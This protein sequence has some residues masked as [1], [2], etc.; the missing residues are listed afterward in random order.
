MRKC[1]KKVIREMKREKEMEKC[2]KRVIR[3]MK[4]GR[5]DKTENEIENSEI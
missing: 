5:D 4:R 3:E 1:S 2:S